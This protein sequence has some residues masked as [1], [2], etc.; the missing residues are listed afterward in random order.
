MD[1]ELEA[2]DKN[3]TWDL[4]MLPEGKHAI[5]C[6]WVFKIMLKQ[7]DSNDRYKARLVAKG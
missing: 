7:D 5:G 3:H 4:T 2:L 6:R 1:K